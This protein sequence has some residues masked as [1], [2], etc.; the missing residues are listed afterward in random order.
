METD[1]TGRNQHEAGAKMDAGKLRASLVLSG[2]ANA[3]HGVCEVG[4]Y[5]A[6]KYTP[7][8]WMTVPD[9]EERYADAQ[10]RHWLKEASG[11]V[12]DEES[13]IMHLKHEAWNVLARLELALRR[14]NR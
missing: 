10:M 5:G 7:D 4:T 9:G 1:P 2:F 3:L 8:G 13:N 14:L 12:I 6:N 11:E